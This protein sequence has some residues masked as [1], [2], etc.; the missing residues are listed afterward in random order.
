MNTPK[1]DVEGE[2][3]TIVLWTDS[4]RQRERLR[5]S[6]IQ[7]FAVAFALCCLELILCKQLRRS[8]CSVDMLVMQGG[9]YV[10]VSR[11]L[12]AAANVLVPH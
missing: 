12:V 2:C 6:D 11:T 8:G 7:H 1:R 5:G 10:S 4:E 9:H 3:C